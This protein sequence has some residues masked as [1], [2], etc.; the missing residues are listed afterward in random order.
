MCKYNY[1]VG[2]LI[3]GA[4]VKRPPYKSKRQATDYITDTQKFWGYG[5]T[6]E[7][8]HPKKGVINFI[9]YPATR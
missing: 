8:V 9:F 3:G 5:V 7:K 2:V 4:W 6:L 1:I